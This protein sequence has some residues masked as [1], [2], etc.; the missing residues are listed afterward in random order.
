MK[1]WMTILFVL[2]GLIVSGQDLQSVLNKYNDHSIPYISVAELHSSPD[3]IW[4]LDTREIVEF[5]VSHIPKAHYVGY[6]AFSEK[7]VLHLVPSN[8]TPI[9]VYCSV[10]V[11]SEK[12]GKRLRELGYQN[13]K[14]L[15]GGIFEWV[16]Q[17][18]SVQNLEGETTEKVHA[19]SKQWGNYLLKGE[20]IF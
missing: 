11:R 1:F 19:F 4:I 16:N 9:V 14:N 7:E 8:E 6:S 13:V 2:I 12:I 15:F 3:E 18:H 10:G 5:E 17:G 20:K